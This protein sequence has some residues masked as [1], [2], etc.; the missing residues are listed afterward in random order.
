MEEIDLCWRLKRAG[1]KVMYYPDA[2]VFHVGGG[3]LNYQSPNKTYLNFRNSYFTII[4]NERKRKLL[5]LIPLR[6][7]LDGVAGMMFL[8]KGQ[9]QHVK[10]IIK[11]HW[12]FFPKIKHLLERRK[13]FSELVQKISIGKSNRNGIVQKSVI[14]RYYVRRKKT[15]KNL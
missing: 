2:E 4:K 15:F 7:I 8:L 9:I 13:H 14:W 1:F 10:A 11:A 6:L 12:H 5:W 3:T